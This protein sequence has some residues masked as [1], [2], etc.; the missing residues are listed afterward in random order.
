MDPARSVDKDALIN[1]SQPFVEGIVRS[2]NYDLEAAFE[3]N[4]QDNGIVL[5][6]I[7]SV[8]A[9]V[10]GENEELAWHWI[11]ML[12]DKKFLYA[13]GCCDYTGWD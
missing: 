12:K 7:E 10:V 4:P 9:E 2:P 6:D 1:I 8:L 5:S 13:T 11:C 3:H